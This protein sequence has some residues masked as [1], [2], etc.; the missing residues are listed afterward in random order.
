MQ[1]LLMG[2]KSNS[3]K[4]WINQTDNCNRRKIFDQIC[5]IVLTSENKAEA[6]ED[7]DGCLHD[8]I[9]LVN[10]IIHMYNS[11]QFRNKESGK[12]GLS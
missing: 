8:D 6:D 1:L 12:S 11:V 3:R 9:A 5:W 10:K 2:S 4:D 7:E